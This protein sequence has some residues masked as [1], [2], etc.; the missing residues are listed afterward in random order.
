MS[1]KHQKK[2]MKLFVTLLVM[3]VATV[4]GYLKSNIEEDINSEL[5][6]K[7]QVQQVSFD[8]EE[9]PEFDGENSYIILNNNIP[10]FYEEDLT[11]K[12]FEQYSELDELGRCGVAFANI[13]IDTMP[14]EDR[15]S[16]GQ[17]KPTGWQTVKYDC[18][19]GKYL[20]NRC[21]LIGYQLTAENANEK[22]LITGTRYMNVE[23]MLPFENMVAE[24]IENTENHVLYR[25]TPVFKDKNLVASGVQIEAKSVEDKGE[26]IS[27]NV[28]VYNA[29][30]NIEIDYLTGKSKLV[31]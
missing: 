20:Y 1:K 2:L 23:G 18:V 19:D 27:F 3:I 4:V 10:E 9:I 21:H 16:I 28:Y 30:P 11:T 7:P 15:E 22:N 13:G 12:S 25:V 26:G 29:Q 14:T 31:K 6:G 17:V 24:Y 5:L 8:I